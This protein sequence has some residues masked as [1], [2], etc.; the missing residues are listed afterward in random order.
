MIKSV[1]ILTVFYVLNGEPYTFSRIVENEAE[2]RS[3]S[4]RALQ[5]AESAGIPTA[6]VCIKSPEYKSNDRQAETEREK[7]IRE[8]AELIKSLQSVKNVSERQQN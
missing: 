2:C 4:V 6:T 3:A 7:R 5:Q 8:T 1:F